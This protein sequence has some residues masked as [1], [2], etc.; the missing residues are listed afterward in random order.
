MAAS[1]GRTHHRRAGRAVTAAAAATERGNNPR[2]SSCEGLPQEWEIDYE[3]LGN[4]Y[5]RARI[6]SCNACVST[7]MSAIAGAE[8]SV[9]VVIP[10]LD[11][12]GH[13]L[14]CLQSVWMQPGRVEALVVDGGSTDDTAAKAMSASATVLRSPRGRGAQCNTGARAASGDMLLFLHADTVLH[15]G[16]VAA[17][18]AAL[19]DERVVGGTFTLRFDRDDMILRFYAWCTRL[20]FR[21]FHYGDQGI[22]VRRATFDSL[23][24]FREWPLM[25]DVD[26]LARLRTAGRTV[27]LPLPV[28]TS[29]RRFARHGVVRQQLQNTALVLLFHLGVAPTRLAAWYGKVR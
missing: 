17:V 25:D 4:V 13:I 28:T 18:R 11:E 15:P 22:F 7:S 3:D 21:L 20:P 6:Q 23:G 27:I 5:S 2:A 19:A 16:A 1:S 10:T 14:A 12:A 26:F 29:A 9:S 24:G 8:T